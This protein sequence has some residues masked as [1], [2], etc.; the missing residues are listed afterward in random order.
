[1]ELDGS[2][3]GRLAGE[4]VGWLC[5]LRSDGSPHLTPVWFLYVQGVLWVGS[6]G[7]TVKVRNVG[8]D[9]RV[10][11]ALQDGDAPV[12]AEG[13]VTVLRSGFPEEVL[14]GLQ[15][16]YGWDLEGMDAPVLLRIAV[17]RW[18]MAGVAR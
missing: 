11:F 16:R 7:N 17:D 1:M 6:S 12:V 15:T 10:S 4:R 2:V 9:P 3:L 14:D 8:G 18:L 5:T 13:T